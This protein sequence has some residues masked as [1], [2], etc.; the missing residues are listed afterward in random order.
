MLLELLL[1]LPVAL[2]RMAP[3]PPPSIDL[4]HEFHRQFVVD[5]EPGRYLGHPSTV[6]TKDD[7]ILVAYPEGHGKGPIRLRRSDDGGRTFSALLETPPS[8][9]TSQETPTLFRVTNPKTNA[10]RLLLFSGLYPIRL[11][12]SD[13]LGARFSELEP[14]GDFGGIVAMSSVVETTP[15]SLIAFFH[16]DGRYLTK[17]GNKGPFT[18]YAT[19]SSNA[20]T[21]WS[22]PRAIASAPGLDLCEPGAVVSPD[23]KRIALLLREN[24]R[25]HESQIVVSDDAGAT[26]SSPRPLPIWLTGDRHVARYASDGRLVLVFRDMEE[27]SAT[28]GDFVGWVGR[29][30]DL[31]AGGSGDC[32][33]RLLDNHHDWDCGY[34]GLE[35]LRD[36]TL[37]ATTYGHFLRGAEPFVVSVRFTLPELDARVRGETPEGPITLRPESRDLNSGW[38]DVYRSGLE[39]I[40]AKKCSLVFLGDSITAAWSGEGGSMFASRFLPRGAVNLGIGGDRTEQILWRLD[41]GILERLQRKDVKAIVLMIGTNDSNGDECSAGDIASGVGAIVDRLRA[42]LPKAKILLLGIFPRN[43]SPEDPQ[44]RKLVRANRMLERLDDGE[45]VTYLD[46]SSRFLRSDGTLTP[47]VMPDLL[48]LSPRGYAIWADAIDPLLAAWQG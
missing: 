44:R 24:S 3:V 12:I 28:H 30:D 18:V 2:D 4:S 1:A 39:A 47:D 32:K 16:D 48:H 36:G 26:F 7:S 38:G 34:A 15:G 42:G 17:T 33:V 11:A 10:P 41:H 21:T 6:T 31:L 45:H 35:S 40:D 13:D 20:G 14:I 46:L 22:E 19:N 43:A 8:F 9:A 29:F 25:K 5:A 27:G 23:G 37:V